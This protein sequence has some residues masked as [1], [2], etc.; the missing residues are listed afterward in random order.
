MHCILDFPDEFNAYV[1][2][3]TSRVQ[4]VPA[5]PVVLDVQMLQ[6]EIEVASES[7]HTRG[8]E[9]RHVIT[10]EILLGMTSE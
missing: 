10:D 8:L 2:S 3:E 6:E 5:N 4:R 7:V 9:E 1:L